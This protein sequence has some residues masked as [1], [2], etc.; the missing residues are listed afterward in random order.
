MTPVR[1]RL[2]LEGLVTT[3]FSVL[4]M[5]GGYGGSFMSPSNNSDTTTE[6]YDSSVGQ[7]E[8]R[9]YPG[10]NQPEPGAVKGTPSLLVSQIALGYN[11]DFQASYLD[12]YMR[13]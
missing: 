7:L 1:A 13:D 8:F 2:G 3:R 10:S 4:G 5:M 11:R 9:F 6:Q 12:G